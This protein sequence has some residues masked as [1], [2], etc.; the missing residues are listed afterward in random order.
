M[1]YFIG[2]AVSWHETTPVSTR[3]EGFSVDYTASK[4]TGTG[5][6]GFW[7]SLVPWITIALLIVLNPG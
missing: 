1:V 5:K 6:A 2:G 4:A 3:P 7:L